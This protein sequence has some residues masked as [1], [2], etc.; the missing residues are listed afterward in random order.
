[1]KGYFSEN[2][3]PEVRRELRRSEILVNGE[4]RPDV[5]ACDTELGFAICFV[6]ATEKQKPGVMLWKR[7]PNGYRGHAATE[8]VWGTVEIRPRP[9]RERA[10]VDAFDAQ[11]GEDAAVLEEHRRVAREVAG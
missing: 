9:E 2:S 11:V 4:V 1:M 6:H 5:V 3:P 7:D 8:L 10:E